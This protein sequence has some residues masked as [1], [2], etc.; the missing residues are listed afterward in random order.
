MDAKQLLANY[1]DVP[2]KL[3]NAIVE[4]NCTRKDFI[5]DRIMKLAGA[6][7]NNDEWCT[8]KEKRI[9]IG[10]YR[11]TKKTGSDNARHQYRE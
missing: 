5:A 7:S 1:R 11:L 10:V 9:I 6:Y 4:S 8:D 2:E 3:I